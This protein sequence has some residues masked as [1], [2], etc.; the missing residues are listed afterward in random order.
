MIRG[1]TLIPE[2]HS[3]HSL[4]RNVQMTSFLTDSFGNAAPVGNSQFCLNL[5]GLPADDP[6]SL[7]E[8]RLLLTLSLHF[9]YQELLYHKIKISQAFFTAGI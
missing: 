5:D 4:L 8:N 6:S 3:G 7:M 9:T 1:T 2:K